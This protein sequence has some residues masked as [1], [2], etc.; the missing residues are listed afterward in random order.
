MHHSEHRRSTV[1]DFPDCGGYNSK[2]LSVWWKIFNYTVTVGICLIYTVF[3]NQEMIT[4][5]CDTVSTE[6]ASS[7]TVIKKTLRGSASKNCSN[8]NMNVHIYCIFLL[9]EWSF[10]VST[11]WFKQKIQYLQQFKS[12]ILYDFLVAIKSKS[13]IQ[14][15]KGVY[16][17]ILYCQSF[18]TENNLHTFSDLTDLTCYNAAI[19]SIPLEARAIPY[20]RNQKTRI[21]QEMNNHVCS[22]SA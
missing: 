7:Y 2:A 4:I 17:R 21:D 12:N 8:C 16:I 9:S 14:Y 5:K 13:K 18:S 15:R 19:A 3:F 10:E 20:L 11:P 22:C 6:K 1:M